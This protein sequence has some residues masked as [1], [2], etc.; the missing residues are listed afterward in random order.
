M[1][2]VTKRF[3]SFST[4]RNSYAPPWV[5]QLE[6]EMYLIVCKG[7]RPLY[8]CCEKVTDGR[9]HVGCLLLLFYTPVGPG[10]SS[11]SPAQF[12]PNPDPH[13]LPP[14]ILLFLHSFFLMSYTA[15]HPLSDFRPEQFIQPSLLRRFSVGSRFLKPN[16]STQ[17]STRP[18]PQPPRLSP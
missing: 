4:T 6:S 9:V 10:P 15:C 2:C 3:F 8:L 13:S 5:L 7:P 14:P 16:P 12:C 17:P 18:C 11:G 1:L